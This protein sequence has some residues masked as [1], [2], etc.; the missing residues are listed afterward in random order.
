MI[1]IA[2]IIISGIMIKYVE[3]TNG[4][5]RS[6][7]SI[8]VEVENPNPNQVL[9]K[10]GTEFALSAPADMKIVGLLVAITITIFIATEFN[11]RTMKCII[12]K[13]FT[14]RRIYLSKVITLSIATIIMLATFIVLSFLTG[15]VVS[16]RASSISSEYTFE[17]I[18][19]LA[20]AFLLYLAIAS[21]FILVN[22][23]FKNM[24]VAMAVN[25][26]GLIFIPN[27]LSSI[28]MNFDIPLT[29]YSV[30]HLISG[31]EN[32]SVSTGKVVE[33]ALVGCGY[34][35]VSVVIGAFLFRRAD[36]K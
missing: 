33:A 8:T 22:F 28:E 6:E 25:I 5:K 2:I 20:V 11:E 29:K 32:L 35:V 13:G 21:I 26:S 34:I 17:A 10:S 31:I 4:D 14:R 24:A 3:K 36:I 1:L 30:I 16:G 18:R 12:A 9:V 15:Y 23:I 7:G 27:L 19:Y